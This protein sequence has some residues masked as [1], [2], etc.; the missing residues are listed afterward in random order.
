M[1]G[2]LPSPERRRRNAPTIPT[3]SL[4]ASGRRGPVPRV[5]DGYELGEAGRAWWVWAWATPQAAGWSTGDL[6]VVARRAALEDYRDVLLR[7]ETGFDLG[8]LL[9]DETGDQLRWLIGR[10]KG[11]A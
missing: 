10:L 11:L 6:Y 7:A 4:P 5:P 9:D 8:D 1:P 3:T 2:P